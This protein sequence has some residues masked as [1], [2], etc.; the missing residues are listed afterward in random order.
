MKSDEASGRQGQRFCMMC[1]ASNPI[2][3]G[4]CKTCGADLTSV[5]EPNRPDVSQIG[6][7]RGITPARELPSKEQGGGGQV[8]QK[9]AL[10]SQFIVGLFGLYGVGRLIMAHW[11]RG[12]IEL[13]GVTLLVIMIWPMLYVP[14]IGHNMLLQVG[15]QIIVDV[16]LTWSLWRDL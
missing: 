14:V 16:V 11:A 10:A 4:Y 2:W 8:R 6:R 1:G 5:V 7:T 12:L 9:I 3:A 13:I 15:P